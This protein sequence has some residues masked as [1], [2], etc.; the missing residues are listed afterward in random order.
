MRL[1]PRQHIRLRLIFRSAST[2]DMSTMMYHA[3]DK[4]GEHSPAVG[5]LEPLRITDVR[6]GGINRLFIASETVTLVLGDS[7]S[8]WIG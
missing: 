4:T 3:S 8:I 2:Y 1:F 7:D 6:D 5:H